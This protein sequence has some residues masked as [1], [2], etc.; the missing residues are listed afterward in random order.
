MGDKIIV[1]DAYSLL[2]KAFFAVRQMS[3]SDGTPTNAVFGFLN[4]LLKLINDEKP[5]YVFAAFDAGSETFRKDIYTDYKANRDSMPEDLRVQVPIIIDLLKKAGVV[6]LSSEGYEADDILGHV[7]K[8]GDERGD[9]TLLVT[10]DRD[11]FQLVSG[12]TNVI[13]SKRGISDVAR[14]DENYISER[15]GVS[16]AQ[17]IDIKALMGDSSDNIPGVSGVGEKTAL[18]LIWQYKTLDG[19]YEALEE[20]KGKLKERLESDRQK[21]YMSRELAEIKREVPLALDYDKADDVNFANEDVLKILKKLEMNS[22]IK[23]IGFDDTKSGEVNPHTEFTALQDAD[24]NNFKGKTVAYSAVFSP[25]SS[26][27]SICCDGRVF[28]CENLA[29]EHVKSFFEDER[30]KKIAHNMKDDYKTLKGMGITPQS[31]VFDIYIASYLCEPSDGRY[32]LK[33]LCAKYLGE[34]LEEQSSGPVQQTL[35]DVSEPQDIYRGDCTK[36]AESIFRISNILSDRLKTE[37]MTKLYNEIEHPLIFVLAEMELDGFSVD[38]NVIRELD[39]GFD[40]RTAQLSAEILDLAGKGSDFNLQ[41]P[42][43][44]GVLLFEE[45]KLPAIKKTKTGYSTDIEVLE[46]LRAAHPVIPKIIELRAISK[47]SSTY[48]KGMLKLIDKSTNRIHSHFNQ[49]ATATGRLS[50]SNPNLQNIPI[51]T[52]EGRVIRKAFVPS[53]KDNVLIDADYSQIELRV[54][55][56]ISGDKSLIE[57][58]KNSEDIHARTAAEVFGIDIKDVDRDMRSSAKAVNFGIVYGISDYGLSRNLDIPRNKAKVYIDKYFDR[59]PGVKKYMSEIVETARRQGYVTTMFER[60][61]YVPDI[62]SANFNIRSFA[63]RI[64]LNAPIQGSAADIIKI[65]MIR[66]FDRLSREKSKA[67][68]IL[69][70]HDELVI[71]CPKNESEDVTNILRE[72]MQGAVSLSV[73]L[74]A[75]VSV[76]GN[77]YDAK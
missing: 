59:F 47:L 52:H 72:E 3:A 53:S 43:Q 36:K 6:F 29:A 28:L 67:R 10:G 73:P 65:A 60:R 25:E 63:E 12:N 9:E 38:I 23:A 56:H 48:T 61:C 57:A 16:P 41:S 50:S 69:Q 33:D 5:K 11:S 71:D 37:N 35:F 8:V 18:K 44:L 24:F 31:M 51:R 26:I 40:A 55:A 2:Y 20:Q 46:K 76:A 49:T 14:V 77:W 54:L 64:A 4:M 17:L 30:I 13:Y 27:L 22:L 34:R 42:K 7:S 66:T 21:A 15:Y 19:V 75:D 58:F 45:L 62:R 74:I 32:G 39:E 68:L 1:I 70:V